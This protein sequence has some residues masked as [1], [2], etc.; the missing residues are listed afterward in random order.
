MLSMLF[1]DGSTTKLL[2]DRS[3]IS[4]IDNNSTRDCNIDDISFSFKINYFSVPK[5]MNNY[6]NV[7]LTRY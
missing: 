1:N 4:K 7:S 2:F 6:E 3:N 5:K